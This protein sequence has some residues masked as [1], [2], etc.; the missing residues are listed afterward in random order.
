M[1]HSIPS[2]QQNGAHL[3]TFI[4]IKYELY[5]YLIMI[6]LLLR[7]ELKFQILILHQMY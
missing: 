4:L 3:P 2:V 1:I 5:L 6:N 7:Y